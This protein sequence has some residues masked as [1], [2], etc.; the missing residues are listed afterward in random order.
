MERNDFAKWASYL[1]TYFPRFNLLPNP[2]ALELWYGELGDLPFDLL[3]AALRKWVN[4]ERFPP[5][6]AELRQICAEIVQGKPEDWGEAWKDVVKAIGR[7]GIY[8]EDKALASLS[9][10]ARQAASRIGWRDICMSENPD[11]LRAQFRQ[12]FQICQQRDI[13]DRQLPPALK[14]T[15]SFISGVSSPQLTEG[16]NK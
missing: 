11:T 8:Q 3:F 15:I 2:E 10:I 12:V 4:T 7:Y 6:I 13:E 1:Q 14:E 5:S 16:G 9:P